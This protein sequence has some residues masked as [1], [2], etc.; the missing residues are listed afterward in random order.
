MADKIVEVS[1]LFDTFNFDL[2]VAFVEEINRYG[3]EPRQ[4]LPILNA[5]PEYSGGIEYGVEMFI[6]DIQV[7]PAG[8]GGSKK[9]ITLNPSREEFSL[10]VYF[11]WKSETD[12]E[13]EI[14]DVLTEEDPSEIDKVYS[15]LKSGDL[16]FGKKRD[17]EHGY[18]YFNFNFTP[19]DITE[20]LGTSSVVFVNDEKITAVLTRA[21]EKKSGEFYTL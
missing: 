8:L 10:C 13:E 14:S 1:S 20:Y 9:S 4:L 17:K 3:Q 21:K 6:R 16:K 5:K 2:L 7:T 15:W 12:L 18:S 19:E 11:H